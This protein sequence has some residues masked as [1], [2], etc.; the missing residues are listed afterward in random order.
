MVRDSR[1]SRRVNWRVLM[2]RLRGPDFLVQPGLEFV[3]G[4]DADRPAVAL[5]GEHR[6]QVGDH[7]LALVDV[8]GPVGER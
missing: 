3:E 8:L 7:R 1:A 2:V 4:L 6:L 5:C